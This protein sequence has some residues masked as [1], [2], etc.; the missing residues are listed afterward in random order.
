MLKSH[1]GC[2][3]DRSRAVTE[4]SLLPDT[5]L[6]RGRLGCD[7]IAVGKRPG[8]SISRREH[9]VRVDLVIHAGPK[10]QLLP[11]L[12]KIV[13]PVL[14]LQMHA[15]GRRAK[16]M[17]SKIGAPSMRIVID[18]TPLRDSQ[19]WK[20]QEQTEGFLYS[21][22]GSRDDLAS[23]LQFERFIP[24]IPSCL[25]RIL[26]CQVPASNTTVC[27]SCLSLQFRASFGVH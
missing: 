7:V 19:R 15:P 27:A 1:P 21:K 5:M 2:E 6:V 14:T 20:H 10:Q 18:D 8:V 3:C 24:G 13:S 11:G 17:I 25:C 4:P 26:A 9:E 22:S 23:S 16:R 12:S